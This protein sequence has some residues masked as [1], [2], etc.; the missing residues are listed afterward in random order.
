MFS[1]PPKGAPL[2]VASSARTMYRLVGSPDRNVG[3]RRAESLMCWS[4]CRY[5]VALGR[6][7]SRCI[8]CR[9]SLAGYVLCDFLHPHLN[10]QTRRRQHVHKRI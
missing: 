9:S 2:H 10:T 8:E 6:N 5:A 7:P 4:Q 1:R 3:W